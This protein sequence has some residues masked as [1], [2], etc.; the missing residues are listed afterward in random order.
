MTYEERRLWLPTYKELP[1]GLAT[2]PQKTD[3]G[4]IGPGSFV[5]NKT[6]SWRTFTPVYDREKCVMCRLC[7]FFCPDG[8]IKDMGTHME[9]DMDYCKGCGIC[10]AECPAGAIKMER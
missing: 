3:A 7:W 9:W 5:E 4:L 10:A 8:A 2:R 1:P 6:G